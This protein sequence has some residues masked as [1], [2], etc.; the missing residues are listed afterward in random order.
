MDGMNGVHL[1]QEYSYNPTLRLIILTLGAGILWIG[2]EAFFCRCLP[3][4][5]VSGLD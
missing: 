4:V 2:M 5:S 3:P 1:P